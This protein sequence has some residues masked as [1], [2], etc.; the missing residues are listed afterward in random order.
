MSKRLQYT[1]LTLLA[2]V[3][4]AIAIFGGKWVGN[5]IGNTT[6][7]NDPQDVATSYQPNETVAPR[8]DAASAEDH[9]VVD[10]KEIVEVEQ[11][12]SAP[13]QKNAAPTVT[14]VPTSA[15]VAPVEQPVVETPAPV[16]V[17]EVQPQLPE[18][19]GDTTCPCEYAAPG[20]WYDTPIPDDVAGQ[21]P[22]E[23]DGRQV[24]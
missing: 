5:M 1:V 4:A 20:E 8:T 24:G 23:T 21:L 17:E 11:T 3:L 14:V 6:Y 15:P 13:V 10:P 16:V 19:Y 7:Q 22:G 9:Y 2:V 18:N 12:T